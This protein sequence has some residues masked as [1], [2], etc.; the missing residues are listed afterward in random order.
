M[1]PTRHYADRMFAPRYFPK[2]GADY[3]PPSTG[4]EGDASHFLR[5]RQAH[6]NQTHDTETGSHFG[7]TMPFTRGTLRL[8][9]GAPNG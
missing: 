1:F 8:T 9:T 4:G 2:V 5:T 3:V 6:S 7:W